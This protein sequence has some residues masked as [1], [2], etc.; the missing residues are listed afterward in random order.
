M[1]KQDE[2][3]AVGQCCQMWWNSSE[4]T[5]IKSTK[6]WIDEK[7]EFSRDIISYNQVRQAKRVKKSLSKLEK[8]GIKYNFQIA[9]MAAAAK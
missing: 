5:G 3:Q 9:E 1:S 2:A 4:A 6:I 8:A 7:D